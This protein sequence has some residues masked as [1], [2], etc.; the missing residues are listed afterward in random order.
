MKSIEISSEAL[1]RLVANPQ[2][3]L[4]RVHARRGRLGRQ[5]RS[6]Y[7][8]DAVD[9]VKRV[10]FIVDEDGPLSVTNDAEGVVAELHEAL[11]GFRVVYRDTE[12]DWDE[13]VHD[14]GV[15]TGYR[16]TPNRQAKWG[17]L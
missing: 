9:A 5:R 3:V 14:A 1:E 15:F 10:I 16:P 7:V 2:T 11:P 12:G 4:D 6:R 17:G 8:V 13:L